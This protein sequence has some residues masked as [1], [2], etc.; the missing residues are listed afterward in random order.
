VPLPAT[1]EKAIPPSRELQWR[2]KETEVHRGRKKTTRGREIRVTGA[3]IV[4]STTSGHCSV[5][6]SLNLWREVEG[7][8]KEE[9][10]K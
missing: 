10:L 2:K 6:G 1:E 7:K 9:N 3:Q 8:R 5:H 4:V